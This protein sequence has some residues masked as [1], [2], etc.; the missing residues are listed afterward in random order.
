MTGLKVFGSVV[1]TMKLL[2]TTDDSYLK[3]R[4]RTTTKRKEDSGLDLYL[5]K[6]IVVPSPSTLNGE[7]HIVDLGI[8][9]EMKDDTG[10]SVGYFLAPR[11]SISR[12]P[13]SFANSIGII[14][15][16]YRGT[17]KLALRNN[18]YYDEP[19]TIQ[20]YSRLGQICAGSLEPFELEVVDDVSALS[21]SE[22]GTG[23]FGSTGI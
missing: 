18:N 7:A 22:R 1:K 15:A 2:L 21:G 17:L 3:Q 16:G 6:K 9:C 11:S 13:V 8:K 12:I 23:G 14:D 4:Y 5:P 20:A 10:E 19:V